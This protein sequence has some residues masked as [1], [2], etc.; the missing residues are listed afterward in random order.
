MQALAA[1]LLQPADAALTSTEVCYYGNKLT[2]EDHVL[3]HSIM[4]VRRP[5]SARLLST[6]YQVT[7]VGRRRRSREAHSGQPLLQAVPPAHCMRSTT[8]H[9]YAAAALLRI[10]LI[11]AGAWQDAHLPVKY[12][13]IDYE[14][15][16]DAARLVSAGRSPYERSTYRYTPLLAVVLTPVLICKPWGK[17]LFSAADLLAGRCVCVIPCII[18]VPLLTTRAP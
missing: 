12:T 17:L 9:V 15:Y 13:D 14:V 18:T 7:S 6:S 10:A 3:K 8:L 4:F 1:H 11:V 5:C 16:S 2:Q